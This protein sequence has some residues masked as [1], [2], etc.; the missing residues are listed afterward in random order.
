MK[1]FEVVYIINMYFCFQYNCNSET[2][3]VFKCGT[4]Q[5]LFLFSFTLNMGVMKLS[6]QITAFVL[7]LR[8]CSLLEDLEGWSPDPTIATRLVQN[9]ISTIPAPPSPEQ[10]YKDYT[11]VHTLVTVNK[12]ITTK[13]LKSFRSSY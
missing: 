1:D 3:S 11:N 4:S 7:V 6:S 10:C 13:N 2:E 9:N 12:R 5:Y 8:T